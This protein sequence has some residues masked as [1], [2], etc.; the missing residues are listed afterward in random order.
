MYAIYKMSNEQVTFMR[1]GAE[2]TLTEATDFARKYHG[3]KKPDVTVTVEVE[4]TRLPV[5]SFSTRRITGNFVKQMWGGRK[6]DE[7]IHCGEED[8]DAT[9]HILSMPYKDVIRIKDNNDTSDEIGMA[10]VTWSGPHEVTLVDSMCDFF[11][12]T[13]IAEISEGHFN[14]VVESRQQELQEYR[15]L[16]RGPGRAERVPSPNEAARDLIMSLAKLTIPGEIG[17]DGKT[18]AP[19]DG[20]AALAQLTSLIRQ[21]REIIARV[22]AQAQHEAAAQRQGAD[23]VE[24]T[25]PRH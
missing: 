24:A 10:H 3:L 20:T 25:A 7:A 14:F 6:G 1:V 9:L 19:A 16:M 21:S 11:G 4:H 17:P 15:A 22:G 8:F 12:V 5:V 13:K 23:D 18:P 2:D